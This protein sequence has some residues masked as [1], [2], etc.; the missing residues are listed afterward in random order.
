MHLDRRRERHLDRKSRFRRRLTIGVALAL[1]LALGGTYLVVSTRDNTD[2]TAATTEDP[3]TL[4]RGASDQSAAVGS[5]LGI[6]FST[7]T[8]G[9]VDTIKFFKV[10]RDGTQHTVRLWSGAGVLLGHGVSTKESGRGWQSVKLDAAVALQAKTTYVASYQS[11]K[12]L[13][14]LAGWIGGR[15]GRDSKIAVSG[16]LSGPGGSLPTQA[17]PARGRQPVDLL[18]RSG[19]QPTATPTSKPTPSGSVPPSNA[20]P[21]G[22]AGSGTGCAA[23]PSRCGY[24]DG[25]NTGVVAGARL[26]SVP[27]DVS[28]G[29]GWHYDKRGWVTVD[30]KGATLENLDVPYN[31]DVTADNV[32]LKNLRITVRGEGFGVSLRRTSNVTIQDVEI[33][34]PDAGEDRLLVGIKDIY[35]DTKGTKILRAD[36]FHA[37]TGVQI[38]SGL[39]QDSYI[40]DMGFRSGDHTN[41]TTSNGGTQQLTIKHNTV[42]NS[43]A[44]TDAVSLFQDFGVEANRLIEGNLLAGGGYT[45][46]GGANPGAAQTS[47][48]RIINNRISNMYFPKGGHF[49]P[50]TAFDE[51]GPGN[52]W[53]GNIWDATGATINY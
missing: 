48:I 21:G 53:A 46:Y 1:G 20:P 24:P 11:T 35:G 10:R 25:S 39:L 44:Q 29:D 8:A 43:Q 3:V 14:Q 28:K 15:P 32:T 4:T 2:N 6:R 33:G 12:D 18:L 50:V 51:H 41:G 38:Y 27:G 26:R 16:V 45:I 19:P 37:G 52:V 49:G 17:R 40:H 9:V 5:E 36:I 30:G 34:S 13:K 31:V 23:N 47:N 22:G 7:P 42:F